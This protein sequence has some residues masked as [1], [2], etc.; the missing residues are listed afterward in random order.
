M[1]RSHLSHVADQDGMTTLRVTCP[2]C[3]EQYE[4]TAPTDGL[5]AWSDGTLIQNALPDLTPSQREGLI[6]GTCQTCWDEM[7]AYLEDEDDES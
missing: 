2:S 3:R 1:R 7:W 5:H 4:V 6:T